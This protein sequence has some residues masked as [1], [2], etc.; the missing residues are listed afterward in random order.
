MRRLAAPRSAADKNEDKVKET[1]GAF[2]VAVKAGDVGVV[3][4]G[5]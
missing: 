5:R 4:I 1:A 3:G 2:L